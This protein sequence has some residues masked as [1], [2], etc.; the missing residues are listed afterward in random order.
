MLKL[1]YDVFLE[2]FNKAVV[3]TLFIP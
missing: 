3:S 1:T 2:L